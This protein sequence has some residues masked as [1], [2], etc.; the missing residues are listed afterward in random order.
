MGLVAEKV[1]DCSELVVY[2]FVKES[3]QFLLKK[4]NPKSS[5]TRIHNIADVLNKLKLISHQTKKDNKMLNR[6]LIK[7]FLE[8]HSFSKCDTFDYLTEICKSLPREHSMNR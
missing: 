8:K 7:I 3:L 2:P 6:E 1:N 5:G 4:Y